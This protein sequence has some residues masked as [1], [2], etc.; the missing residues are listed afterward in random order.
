MKTK[1]YVLR[2]RHSD[3][4]SSLKY[5]VNYFSHLFHKLFIMSVLPFLECLTVCSTWG[6]IP[7]LSNVSVRFM[8]F[9]LI[10][11]LVSGS[12]FY[13]S[14]YYCIVLDEMKD[15][16]PSTLNVLHWDAHNEREMD[17]RKTIRSLIYAMHTS[18]IVERYLGKL[19]H[20]L[21]WSNILS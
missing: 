4:Y 6:W 19:S 7:S 2:Q 16:F 8:L 20:F 18:C 10:Y 3:R 15:N 5:H 21:K 17:G 1:I 11:K 12:F 14:E 9:F 13:I